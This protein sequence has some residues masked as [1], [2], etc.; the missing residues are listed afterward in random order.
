MTGSSI[1]ILTVILRRDI[2]I[3]LRSV[4]GWYYALFFYG[5]F[6]LLA[7]LSFGPEPHLLRA[8][9]P[10]IVWLAMALSLQFS[11]L[12]AFREDL[13]DGFVYAHAAETSSLAPYF[14]SKLL[15]LLVTSAVP[16]IGATPLALAML[17]VDGYSLMSV[18]GL[19]VIGAIAIGIGVV[20][21]AS[22][23][24]GLR[25][26]GMLAILLA[27]PI[28]GPTLIFGTLAMEQLLAGGVFLSPETLLLSALMLFL[29]VIGPTFGVMALR[30]GLE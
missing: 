10:A 20:F 14:L 19:L 28:M 7:A 22:V 4:G 15:L 23:A 26:G 12:D 25:A 11:A 2:L 17:A 24:A 6:V 30:A 3:A 13:D 21:T 9:A 5:L 1:N 27:V 16:I 29:I 18:I 8:A